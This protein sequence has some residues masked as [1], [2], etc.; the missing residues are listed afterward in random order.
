[1]EM[2]SKTAAIQRKMSSKRFR[3]RERSFF[4]RADGKVE[5]ALC[6]AQIDDERRCSI[7]S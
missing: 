6:V 3:V 1:M 7:S 5:N 4:F 2:P